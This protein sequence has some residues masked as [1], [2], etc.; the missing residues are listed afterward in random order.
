M[1]ISFVYTVQLHYNARCKKNKHK[2]PSLF[3]ESL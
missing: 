2:I 3:T 1:Y